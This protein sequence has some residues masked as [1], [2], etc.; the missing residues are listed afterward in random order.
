MTFAETELLPEERIR[1]IR[2]RLRR[3]GRE[4]FRQFPWRD[5]E[6]DYAG[7]IAEVLLQRT[8]ASSV[9]EV[10][11][12]FLAR[13]PDAESLAAASEEEIGEVMRPL[14]LRWRVPLVAQLGR[15]LVELGEVPRD[16]DVLCSLPGVGP[17]TAAAW[18]SFH[19]K[20]RGVLVDA[21]VVRWIARL[22]GRPFDAETR[23]KRWLLDLAEQI[24]P[25]REVKAFNYALLD[26]TMAVCTPG[27]PRCEVCPLVSICITGE[28]LASN[29]GRA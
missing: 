21:N 24:T 23:R 27:R 17:Y 15:R 1:L 29:K 22:T 10:Y 6:S 5:A 11:G 9:A 4:H 7:L 3:W 12:A 26:F 25:R 20:G 14:G 2:R 8:R 18:L 16:Y 19:G 13:Y 28:R